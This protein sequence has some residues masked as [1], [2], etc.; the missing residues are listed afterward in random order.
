MSPFIICNSRKFIGNILDDYCMYNNDDNDNK[1]K[2]I[3][4]CIKLEGSTLC[5]FG[6]SSNIMHTI[7]RSAKIGISIDGN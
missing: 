6:I 3:F 2:L 1:A 7:Y 5:W 4:K